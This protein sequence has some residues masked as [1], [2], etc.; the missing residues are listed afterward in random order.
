MQHIAPNFR[1]PLWE[2]SH[3]CVPV[4]KNRHTL[5]ALPFY[6]FLLW[7]LLGVLTFPCCVRC[8]IFKV[9]VLGP[10]NCDPVFYKALPAAAARLAVSRINGD[11]ALDLGLKMDFIIVQEPCETSKALT[12]YIYYEGIA[13]G[14]VG[15]TNPGYCV[16]ASLLARN[17]DKALF[18]YGCVAYE[19]ESATAY[20]T[21][22]RTVPFP[23]DVLFVVLK[24]FRWASVLVVSSNEDIWIDTAVRVASA[25]RSKGLPVRLVGSMG[26]NETEVEST[27][28]KIQD[29]GGVRGE[30]VRKTVLHR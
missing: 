9:G 21:F 18:S 24:H 2:S 11:A 15:P 22:T 16:A 17:W 30:C 4:I 19:L 23:T 13:G 5:P 26:V 1:W 8:L 12:A 6:N 28:R 27:M 20:P 10:W 25:L 14:L 7:V 29:A 3:S